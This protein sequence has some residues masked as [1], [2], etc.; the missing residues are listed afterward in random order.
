[1]AAIPVNSEGAAE[2]TVLHSK[3]PWTS[4][5]MR[6]VSD[7]LPNNKVARGGP[8]LT[9]LAIRHRH[10]RSRLES[11]LKGHDFILEHMSRDNL[12]FSVSHDDD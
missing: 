6:I 12:P 1:M 2:F 5:E 10:S 9:I 4:E 8:K 3:I 7:D 11:L